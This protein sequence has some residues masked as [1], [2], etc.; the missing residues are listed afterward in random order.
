MAERIVERLGTPFRVGGREVRISTSVGI[1]LSRPAEGR[2]I[3]LIRQADGAMYRAKA[4]GAGCYAF[5]DRDWHP[6]FVDLPS[7]A[8]AL[9][10]VE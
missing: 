3:E 4:R 5:A 8:S 10:A 1:A 6:S 9:Y 2:P 7:P